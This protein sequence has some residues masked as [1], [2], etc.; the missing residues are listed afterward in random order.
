MTAWLKWKEGGWRE[1]EREDRGTGRKIERE[2]KEKGGKKEEGGRERT[3]GQ[4]EGRKEERERREGGKEEEE[5]GGGYRNIIRT[6][7]EDQ[8]YGREMLPW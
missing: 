8:D 4:R 5:D 1:G 3:Q 2:R 6:R 7:S